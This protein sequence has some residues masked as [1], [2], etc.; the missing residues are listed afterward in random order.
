M[1]IVLSLHLKECKSSKS[2]YYFDL[3]K[4]ILLLVKSSAKKFFLFFGVCVCGQWFSYA[5]T[6]NQLPWTSPKTSKSTDANLADD[7]SYLKKMSQ[8]WF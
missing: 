1:V 8:R 6:P 7:I 4:A 2:Y 3:S 5:V